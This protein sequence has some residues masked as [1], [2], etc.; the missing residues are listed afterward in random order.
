MTRTAGNTGAEI[1]FLSQSNIRSLMRR[2]RKAL[3]VMLALLG[4]VAADALRSPSRQITARAYIAAV[5]NYQR[6]GRPILSRWIH[7]RYQPTCSEYSVQAVR[8]HGIANGLFLTGRRLFSCFPNVAL[9][10]IDPVPPAK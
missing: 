5:Q 9:G 4:A 8:T 2:H 7:C 10:T 6:V 3:F 1:A